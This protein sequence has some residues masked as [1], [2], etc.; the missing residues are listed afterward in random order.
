[1]LRNGFVRVF[2][3]RECYKGSQEFGKSGKI[4]QIGA[5]DFS[6]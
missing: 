6:W 5:F 3:A 1:M 4:W 2:K